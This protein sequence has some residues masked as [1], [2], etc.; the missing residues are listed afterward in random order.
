[1]IVYLDPIALSVLILPEK[2]AH[3]RL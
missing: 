2:I 3:M 1:M